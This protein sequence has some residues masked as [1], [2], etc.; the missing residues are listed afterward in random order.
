M[1]SCFLVGVDVAF[2][3]HVDVG[4]GLG[5]HVGIDVHFIVDVVVGVGLCGVHV[6]CDIFDDVDVNV[7]CDI[8]LGFFFGVD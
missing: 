1:N 8:G 6:Y 4:V 7:V 5:V 2:G 3:V